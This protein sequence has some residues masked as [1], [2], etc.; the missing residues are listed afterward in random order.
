MT[1]STATSYQNTLTRSLFTLTISSLLSL[2]LIGCGGDDSSSTTNSSNNGSNNGSGNN[3]SGG[4]GNNNN[5]S[6]GNTGG[7]PPMPPVNAGQFSK[8]ATWEVTNFAPNAQSC[9]DFDAQ[10]AS[11]CSGTTWDVKFENQAR[12]V[13]LWSNSGSSG[14]GK[15]GVFGLMDWQ[16]LGRYRNATQNPDSGR[17]IASHY[18]ADRSGGIFAEQPWFE[19]NLQGKH[20]LYPNNRVYRIT[21]DYRDP[22][23]DS[24]VLKPVYALQIINYYSDTGK[25]AQPTIR[26]IDTALPNNVQTLTVDA[27]SNDQWVYVNLKTGQHSSDKNSAWHIG[28]KRNDVILNGGDSSSE[29]S[30]GQVGGALAIKPN[31]YYV[32][33]EGADKGEVIPS[34]FM[35]DGSEATLKDLTTVSNYQPQTGWVIDRQGSDLNPAYTGSFPNLDFGW[36]IYNGATHQLTAKAK[37]ASKGVLLRSAEGNSYAR[38]RL[39]SINYPNGSAQ[40]ASSWVF[41]FDIQPAIK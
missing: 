26:W 6:S 36:Y 35:T 39:D 28:F 22:S 38:M 3:N 25:S 2:S 32:N 16:D 1:I 34:K 17:D 8:S 31:G 37:N 33:K 12:G 4:G 24:T 13:K 21:T 11:D 15:G 41:H 20:Q 14:T 30:K 10:A 40:A 9:Y 19:Y 29:V 23:T 5:G 18:I 7:T 27:S